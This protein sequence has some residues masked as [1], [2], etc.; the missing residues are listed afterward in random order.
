MITLATTLTVLLST[1]SITYSKASDEI[2][3]PTKVKNG[4]CDSNP[5]LMLNQC[6]DECFDENGDVEVGAIGYFQTMRIAKDYKCH[7]LYEEDAD[8]DSCEDMA[9]MDHC[10]LN[11]FFMLYQCAKS[12]LVC[13]KPG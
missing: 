5:I 10:A 4:E 1:S 6:R 9:G 7:D 8:D 12:C 2:D 13:V 11:P 3:C